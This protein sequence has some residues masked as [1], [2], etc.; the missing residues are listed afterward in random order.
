MTVPTPLYLTDSIIPFNFK[1]HLESIGHVSSGW[2]FEDGKEL[3]DD[4]GFE[5]EHW[6]YYGHFPTRLIMEAIYS[7]IGKKGIESGRN[8]LYAVKYI[9]FFA[10]IL[11]SPFLW[12]DRFFSKKRKGAFLTIC[13]RKIVT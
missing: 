2:F 6:S 4:C 5:V 7:I 1:P 9:N 13:S 8:G 10:Y 3:L 12:V 11:T